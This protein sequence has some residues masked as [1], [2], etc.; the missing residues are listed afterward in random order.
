MMLMEIALARRDSLEA[1]VMNAN[2]T[3]L[4][5][6]VTHVMKP[7]LTIRHARV[8]PK[9]WFMFF[10]KINTYSVSISDCNCNPGGSIT[11]ECNDNGDCACK[12]GYAGQKCDKCKP[13]MTGETCDKCEETFFNYPSCQGLFLKKIG[14]WLSKNKSCP[15]FFLRL[16]M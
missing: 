8:C 4:G 3:S 11:L 2:Q 10:L 15:S 5:K 7:S 16:Q 9:S 13:N 12:N 14:L 1:N 6:S